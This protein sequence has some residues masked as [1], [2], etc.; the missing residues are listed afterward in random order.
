MVA[1][2]LTLALFLMAGFVAFTAMIPPP[3]R[4]EPARAQAIVALTGDASRVGDAL[5]LLAQGRG[6]RLLITG[7]N[8]KTTRSEIAAET[9]GFDYLFKCCIDLG[10]QASNTLGNAAETRRW[11]A[12]EGFRRSLIIVTS[13]YH[14]PRALAE[15]RAAM[16][17]K[18]LI[19][20]PVATPRLEDRNWR[21]LLPNLR[22]LGW[23]YVKYL[24]AIA[25]IAFE[26]RLHPPA[27]GRAQKSIL[28]LHAST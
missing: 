22:L 16:P 13:T 4:G 6:G 28:A 5:A 17:N 2:L 20:F 10:Y 14:M 19:P 23:E 24:I 21:M 7:V 27:R 25:R 8:R 9:P 3:A 12:R 1:A 11:A 15:M 18:Q 26:D